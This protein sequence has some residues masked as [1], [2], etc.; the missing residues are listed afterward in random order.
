MRFE[1]IHSTDY[2]YHGSAIEAYLEARLTPPE[3]ATQ[4]IIEHTI[5]I[6]P[7]L[8]MTHYTDTFGNPVAFFSHT[9]RH[10]RLSIRNRLLVE[11]RAPTL[12]DEALDLP[13]AEARQLFSSVLLD[14]FD[15]LQPT[16]NVPVGAHA[17]DW[18]HQYLRPGVSL[19]EGFESLN[20]A[21][22]N[23]FAYRPGSTDNS[24]PLPEVWKSKRGVCQDF[25]HVM[26]S[27]LRT[28]GLPARYVCGYI[29]TDAPRSATGRRLVGAVATHAWVEALVPGLEWVALD[30]TN[31]RWC[32]E[33]HVAVSFGRDN[34]DA[35]PV[36]GTFKG[37]GGQVMKIRV[38][39]K[40]TK[41]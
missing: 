27:V 34:R 19:R 17:T 31:N 6:A 20:S 37:G 24:T 18:A 39:M 16:Q 26:L 33:Q 29:E 23:T 38:N 21:I 7:D 41:A 10:D 25:A 9:L 28:A 13:I 8:P 40:R 3:T 15:Y 30:P 4:H 12:P 22:Y 36:R 1:I 32:A 5:E 11:T 35:A 14:F 2:R